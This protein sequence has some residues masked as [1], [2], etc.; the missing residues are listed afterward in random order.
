MTL[1]ISQSHSQDSDRLASPSSFSFRFSDS[2]S[3]SLFAYWS[4]MMFW[5]SAF[6]DSAEAISSSNCFKQSDM[7]SPVSKQTGNHPLTKFFFASMLGS[8]IAYLLPQ[9]IPF[10]LPRPSP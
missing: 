6:S 2:A 3:D 10:T 9:R 8:F 7:F 5:L 4:M 1:H